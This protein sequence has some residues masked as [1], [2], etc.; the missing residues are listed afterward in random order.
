MRLEEEIKRVLKGH[1][2]VLGAYLYGSIAK[3]YAGKGSDIDVG[4]LL[5]KDFRAEALYAARIAGEIKEKCR[6]SQEV[7]VR[8]L[9]GR[10]YRFLYQVIKS[11]RVIL[12]SDEKERVKF[13]TSVTD[14]YIDFKPFYKQY[15]EKRRERLLECV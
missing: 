9:N 5:R 12:F 1:R 6:L 4:L 10:S 7:D 15:D 8:I 14:R 3:G 2:E 13:E 11:G